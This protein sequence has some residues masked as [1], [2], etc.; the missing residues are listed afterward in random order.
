MSVRVW[1]FK[2][3]GPPYAITADGGRTVLD[4]TPPVLADTVAPSA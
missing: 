4:Y 1:L 3:W 2:I